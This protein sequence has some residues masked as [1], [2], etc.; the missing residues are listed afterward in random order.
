MRKKEDPKALE[1]KEKK[2]QVINHLRALHECVMRLGKEDSLKV[3]RAALWM[4]YKS[5]EGRKLNDTTK[6][7]QYRP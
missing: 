1:Q 4:N 6:R 3:A 7:F 2:L 5:G